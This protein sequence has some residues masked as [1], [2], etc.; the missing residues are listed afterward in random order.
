[1]TVKLNRRFVL[2]TLTNRDM[3]ARDLAALSGISEATMYRLM[4][5]AAF[6]SDTLGKL[7]GALGCHP[8]DLI[9]AEGFERPHVDAP[10][11]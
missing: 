9:E 4:G 6:N 10:A 5:G 2:H 11:A 7:A 8:V 3:T 1:M